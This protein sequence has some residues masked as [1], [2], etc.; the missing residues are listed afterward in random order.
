TQ[1]GF[2]S[3]DANFGT[4]ILLT[5][6]AVPFENYLDWNPYR[7]WR[8][9]VDHYEIFRQDTTPVSFR[10]GSTYGSTNAMMD[11]KLNYNDGVYRYKVIAHE[12]PGGQN[13]ISVSNEIEL[14]QAPVL[15][16]P[17]AFTPNGDGM[18]DT[19][20]LVPAFVKDYHLKVF[21]RWGEG[22]WE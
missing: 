9:K 18:N 16:I 19:W 12:G 3:P 11:D 6:R 2:S 15:H 1:C 17:N 4:S 7:Q 20:R 21:N 10:L 8:G 5:G 14:I 22:I 13:A